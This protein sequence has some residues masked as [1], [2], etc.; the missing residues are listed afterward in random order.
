VNLGV[1]TLQPSELAKLAVVVWCAMLAAKKGEQLRDFKNGVLPFVVILLPVVGLIFLEPHLSMALLVAL[2]AGSVLFTAGA[3]IGHVL[4]SAWQ[5]G[6]CCT[7]RSRRRSTGSPCVDVSESRRRPD[8]G[9][10]AGTAIAHGHRRGQLLGAASDR[11]NRSSA[12]SRTHTPISFSR[13]SVRSGASWA[14]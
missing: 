13:R 7:E 12:I 8:G 9:N 3:R 10:V 4:R 11:V 6:R 2:L 1:L 5:R 14:W